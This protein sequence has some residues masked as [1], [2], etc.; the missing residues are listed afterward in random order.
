MKHIKLTI[1]I[2]CVALLFSGCHNFRIAASID[3]LISPI[4]PSG[5]NAGVQ[6]ALD[7]YCKSGY[8]IKIPTSGKYT[9]SFVFE[10][11]TGDGNDEAVAFYMP[12]DDLGSVCMA[13]IS[14]SSDKWSVVANV[15]GEATDVKSVDFCDLNDDGVNE[16][17]VCWSVISKST[18]FKVN[19]YKQSSK[20]GT[21]ALKS[22]AKSIQASDFICLDINEDK[23]NDLLVFS[24][25]ANSSSASAELYSFTNNKKKLMGST[26]L[27]S[28]I[29]SFANITYGQ[30]DEGVSVYADGLKYDSS[31]M[32]TEFIYWSNYYNSIVSPFYNYSTGRTRE[33]S[34][35]NNLECKDIDNDG[36]IEIPLD[37]SIANLPSELDAENWQIYDNTVLKHKCYSVSCKRDNY[38]LLIPDKKFS[39][40]NVSYDAN[41]RLMKITPLNDKKNG[42][43]IVTIIQSNYENVMD[44]YKD[45]EEIFSDSG[46]VYL[47]KVDK[48]SKLDITIDELKGM[49]KAY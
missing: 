21:V 15:N 9:T 28:S 24:T 31:S 33:T 1:L 23:K 27:D 46:F 20:N 40:L 48:S 4:S 13:L 18:G 3:E 41:K 45:Y 26:K 5:D 38:I 37:I 36:E 11:I 35:D 39:K 47:A 42:L 19:V 34:R 29:T 43:S 14:K 17:V 22:I 49:I 12:S 7:E 25:N 6:N 16:I 32:V 8:S 10:D 30:T 2:L 44:E